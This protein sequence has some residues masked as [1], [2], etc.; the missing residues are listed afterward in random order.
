MST[1]LLLWLWIR[2]WHFPTMCDLSAYPLRV[3]RYTYL[4]NRCLMFFT[5]DAKRRVFEFDAFVSLSVAINLP[6]LGPK[7]MHWLWNVFIKVLRMYRGCCFFS[8]MDFRNMSLTV[9]GWG[10]TRQGALTSSRYLLETR[11]KLVDLRTCSKSSI[12]KENLVKDTMMCAYSLGK[13]ACQVSINH[14]FDKKWYFS[15]LNLFL[16]FQADDRHTVR[17]KKKSL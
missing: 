12:Y 13:D 17:N 9:A 4:A 10:K 1:I 11:V 3:S 6:R 5:T 8:D 2:S 7:R 14:V 16:K 15:I